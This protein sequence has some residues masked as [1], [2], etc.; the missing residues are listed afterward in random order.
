MPQH[1]TWWIWLVTVLLLVVGLA[2]HP[3][4]FIAAIVLSAGQSVYFLWRLRAFKPYAVQI[5][6]AYTGLL[7]LCFVPVMRWLYWLPTCGTFALIL[8]GYCL[9]A[10]VLSLMPWNRP[11]P[12]SLALLSRVLFTS[13]VIGKAAHGLPET[14]CMGGVCE[15]EARV[16]TR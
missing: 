5:R 3:G 8:F 14:G 2:M 16:A 15:T 4:G 13:P 6:V 11:G 7:L 9:M 10:R 12:M 1:P